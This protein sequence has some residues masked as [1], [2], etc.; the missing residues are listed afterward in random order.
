MA[1]HAYKN[2]HDGGTGAGAVLI[3]GASRGIGRACA[4]EFAER[5]FDLSLCC[6]KNRALLEEVAE[7]ASAFGVR[8]V[9]S[10]ADVSD[11][12]ETERMYLLT[13]DELGDI[14]IVVNNAGLSYV[15]LLTD[16]TPAEWAHV[17]S[18]NLTSVFNTCRLAVPSM[19]RR[20]HGSIVNV[21]SVWGVNGAS[22]EAAYSASKGGVNALTQ[23]LAK[24]LAPSGVRV[25][26]VAC[27]AVDTDMNAC[28]SKEELASLCDE[29]PAGRLAS[30]AEAAKLIADV[31]TRHDYMTGQIIRLDGGWL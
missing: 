31:A 14:D 8:V 7:Q 28:F 9:T 17:I 4:L 22:C 5:G 6:V 24:E 15:G 20:R 25:N 26:A 16:M 12:A 27:G 23:A 29:I 1:A 19:V 3:T 30:P 11:F 21:S 2:R 10:V 18:V 13:A